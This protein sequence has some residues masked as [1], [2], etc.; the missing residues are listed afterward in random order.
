M[1]Q[2]FNKHQLYMGRMISHSKSFYRSCYPYN[3]VV[4]NAGFF[5]KNNYIAIER[6]PFCS[7][8]TLFDRVKFEFKEKT[9]IK[10]IFY[11]DIDLS[12]EGDILVKIAKEIGQT[13]YVLNEFDSTMESPDLNKAIWSTKEAVPYVTEDKIKEI[14]LKKAEDTKQS[15]INFIKK[16]RNLLIK[17]KEL[18]EV[19]LNNK[20]IKT[21]ELP[22]DL[23]ESEVKRFKENFNNLKKKPNRE[24]GSLYEE[25]FKEYGY[26]TY[27]VLDKFLTKELKIKELHPSS[28]WFNRKTNRYL[29]K[30]DLEIERLFDPKFTY[31]DF[32]RFVTSNYCVPDLSYSLEEGIS[33]NSY[34]DNIIYIRGNYER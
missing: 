25:F 29:R 12:L 27:G 17:N 16:S 14:E 7:L 1:E 24:K 34:K 11:G 33:L 30:V 15:R 18:K 3:K 13:I 19:S 26:F 20:Y 10:K 6:V 22:I 9:R 2:I 5:V 28:I 8:L 23:I 31:S 32:K 4:F 21:I